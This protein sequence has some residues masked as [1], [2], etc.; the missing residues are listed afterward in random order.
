MLA[1]AGDG[2]CHNVSR[3]AALSSALAAIVSKGQQETEGIVKLLR[4]Q[5][6]MHGVESINQSVK[7]IR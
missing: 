1:R 7:L 5:R 6:L 3:C 2:R 4:L